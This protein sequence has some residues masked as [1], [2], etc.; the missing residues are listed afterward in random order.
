[1]ARIHTEDIVE[2]HADLCLDAGINFEGINQRLLADSGVSIVAGAKRAG[3][4]L[5]IARTLDR[6]TKNTDIISSTTQNQLKAIGMVP[7]CPLTPN[8]LLRTCGSQDIYE[9][10]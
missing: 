5:W 8:E 7:E 10:I 1:M 2:E 3:D 6:L 9:K 4:E